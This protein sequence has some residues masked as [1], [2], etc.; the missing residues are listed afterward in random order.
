MTIEDP[1]EGGRGCTGI[2][3]LLPGHSACN[4]YF[5]PIDVGGDPPHMKDPGGFP[6]PG[7]TADYR[8]ATA[9]TRR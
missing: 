3:M 7:R 9:S 5:W 4:N 1:G 8:E 2:V 6:P